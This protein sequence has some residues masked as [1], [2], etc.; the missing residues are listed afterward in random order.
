MVASTKEGSH[1]GSPYKKDH[2]DIF[3]CFGPPF[4]GEPHLHEDAKGPK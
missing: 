3:G 2:D 1:S 4:Y